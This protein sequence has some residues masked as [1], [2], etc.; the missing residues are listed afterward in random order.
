MGIEVGAAPA[1]AR[2]RTLGARVRARAL[3]YWPLAPLL[4]GITL[5][6]LPTLW[7]PFGPDQAIFAT[8]GRTINQGG[9]PYA[10]AWDQKPPAIYFL[11]A[12][13][14][15]LPGPMMAR[16]RV[17]DLVWTLVT[18]VALY[19]LARSMWNVRAATVAALLYGA[20]YYTTQGWWYLAQPDGFIA[21]PLVLALLL[22]RAA[23]GRR[24]WAACLGAGVLAGVAFQLRFTVGLLLPLFALTDL[25]QRRD[26]PRAAAR[27][28]AGLAAGFLAVQ[29]VLVAY[30]AAGDAFR[31]YVDATRFAAG[32][33]Q[34]GWPYAPRD[35]TFYQF[36]A[37]VRGAFLSFALSHLVLVLPAL[38]AAFA[39]FALR[40]DASARQ[41]TLMA[42]AAFAGIAL[43]QKFFW[44]HWQLMLP[45]LALL[46]GRGWDELFTLIEAR[47]GWSARGAA[48]KCALVTALLLATPALTDYA[49]A[50]WDD[51]L[52]RNESLS[53][54]LQWDNQFGA[55]GEGTF[56]YLADVQ[57]ADYLREHTTPQDTVY[58]WGYDPLIY[59]LSDRQSASRFIYALPMMSHWAPARWRDEFLAEIDRNRPLYFIVQRYE[60]A[61]RWITGQE[62][63]TAAWAWKIRGLAGRL[64]HD[65]EEEIAI[66]DFTLYRRK[67]GGR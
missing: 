13:A 4:L 14:L 45:L 6:A 36:L 57:V 40:P 43:Q 59:L 22:Y 27:R 11:Y 56:S 38:G 15:R 31:E 67:D 24:A 41:L 12:L 26:G 42:L 47:L 52:H 21:L 51:F 58:V 3:D 65:Y 55:Y 34:T 66:E 1:G 44:Y 29:A 19:E 49:Y 63:D 54:R 35:P 33:I 9:F 53:R 28:L 16:V 61:A 2:R 39:A 17:F 50:Q 18:M 23:A 62:E 25:W 32:Y 46:A 64:E 7:Y 30:L 10:D 20:V 60:G 48:A 37:F 8:I 5:L